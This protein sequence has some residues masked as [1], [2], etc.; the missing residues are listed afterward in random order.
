M[1]YVRP[2]SVPD[3]PMV[4][5]WLAMPHVVEWWGEPERLVHTPD[6]VALLMVRNG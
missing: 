4:R 1:A 5:R 6:G 3:L 2:M